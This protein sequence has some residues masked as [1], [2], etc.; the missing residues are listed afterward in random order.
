[1]T[2]LEEMQGKAEDT[3]SDLRKKE[4]SA[5]HSFAM[6]KGGLENEIKHSQD[7]LAM[8]KSGSAAATE[9]LSQAQ[10]ELVQTS[11]T[12]AADEEY[13]STLKGE[14]ETK[15]A[16]WGERQASANEE[17]AVIEKAKEILTSGVKAFVQ[18]NV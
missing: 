3:L 16:E 13:A 11:K 10:G 12:K 17:M 18:V 15:A 8:A 7:K 2:T 1:M 9:A 14:C 5:S 6:V 4:M